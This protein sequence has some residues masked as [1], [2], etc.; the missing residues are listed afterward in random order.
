[1]SAARSRLA[2]AAIAAFAIACCLGAPL[3]VGALGA[4]G[5]GAAFGIG[6]GLVALAA[7]SLV[8][9]RQ[10]ARAARRRC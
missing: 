4:V 1:M 7:L 10:G 9:L 5:V 2:G 6:A 8:A 3:L